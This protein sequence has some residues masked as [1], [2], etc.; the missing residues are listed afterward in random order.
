MSKARWMS[1]VKEIRALIAK[2]EAERC[3]PELH[4]RNI[5]EI[6]GLLSDPLLEAHGPIREIVPIQNEL[7][8]LLRRVSRKL[9]RDNVTSVSANLAGL[10]EVSRVHISLVGTLIKMSDRINDEKLAAVARELFINWFS[11]ASDH[12]ATLKRPL[13]RLA[14]FERAFYNDTGARRKRAVRRRARS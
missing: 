5:A 13:S 4:P 2:S 9:N 7:A 6:R 1:D 3:N 12:M 14:G 11:N 10:W 8:G